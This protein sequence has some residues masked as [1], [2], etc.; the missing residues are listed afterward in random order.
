MR[1]LILLLIISLALLGF[2][3]NG[4]RPEPK[5]VEYATLDSTQTSDESQSSEEPQK[6]KIFNEMG[7]VLNE[8]SDN[9]G[10]KKTVEITSVN[11]GLSAKLFSK[12]SLKV[13]DENG[14]TENLISYKNNFPYESKYLKKVDSNTSKKI[15]IKNFKSQSFVSSVILP[16]GVTD[17]I[18]DFD[19]FKNSIKLVKERLSKDKLLIPPHVRITNP[20]KRILNTLPS[21][22]VFKT[23]PDD[24]DYHRAKNLR[25]VNDKNDILYNTSKKLEDAKNI[26]KF[27]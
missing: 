12:P 24:F 18:E 13:T 26:F 27:N 10:S 14:L 4:K 3:I 7:D 11:V 6:V 22:I 23:K 25:A 8:T 21:E 19:Y 16:E 20:T 9:I 17:Y 1:S 5:K 2:K 15:P